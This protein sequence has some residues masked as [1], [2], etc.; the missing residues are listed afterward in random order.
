MGH[1]II[2]IL[3]S[4]FLVDQLVSCFLDNTR[5]T[6][7]TRPVVHSWLLTLHSLQSFLKANTFHFLTQ[8]L[9]GLD[10]LK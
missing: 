7:T 10:N 4:Q 3:F 8:Y 5:A 9:K 2:S 6:L 1:K